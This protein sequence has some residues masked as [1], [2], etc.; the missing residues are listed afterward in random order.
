MRRRSHRREITIMVAAL[1]AIIRVAGAEIIYK[2]PKGFGWRQG[3][4]VQ[5]V[6]DDAVQSDLELDA[7]T[8][9]KLAGWKSMV[10]KAIDSEV[11]SNTDPAQELEKRRLVQSRYQPQL[12]EILNPAQQLRLDEI[13]LQQA[14]MNALSDAAVAKVLRLTPEQE[15]QILAIHE[16][17][18][19]EEARQV[20]TRD[21]TGHLSIGARDDMLLA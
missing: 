18:R 10:R 12:D 21:T 3:V 20:K 19:R 8:A 11:P 1:F 14:G 9:H 15:Q 5:L 13:H 4:P 7:A 2:I 16:R 17:M 6:E